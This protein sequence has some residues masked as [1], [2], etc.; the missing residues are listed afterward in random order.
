[1]SKLTRRA[2]LVTGGLATLGFAPTVA[3]TVVT[4]KG[5]DWGLCNEN[6]DNQNAARYLDA[7]Q[8]YSVPAGYRQIYGQRQYTLVG[9]TDHTDKRI[10]DFFY[11]EGNIAAMVEGGIKHLCLE[12]DRSL[13]PVIDSLA[14]GTVLPEDYASTQMPDPLVTDFDHYLFNQH[15]KFAAAIHTMAGLGIQIHCIDTVQQEKTFISPEADRFYDA[16]REFHRDMCQSPEGMTANA[17]TVFALLHAF[18]LWAHHDEMA[19]INAQRADDRQR[20]E[21]TQALC[22]NDPAIIFMGNSHFEKRPNSFKGLLGPDALHIGIY[23][24]SRYY[25]LP[26]YNMAPD[27]VHLVEQETVYRMPVQQTQNH[28]L[29]TERPP[30]NTL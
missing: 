28:T 27:F 12:K 6:E 11:G 17:Q 30:R 20:L 9:E 3:R 10:D 26:K 2:L 18:K 25:E 7:Q 19:L 1:M 22:G 5:D 16:P 23:G 15:R 29:Q 21:T 24:D 8:D 4:F 14:N 13:Q